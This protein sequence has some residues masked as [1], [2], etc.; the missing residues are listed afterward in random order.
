MNYAEPLGGKAGEVAAEVLSNSER[1][2]R[3]DLE[4]FA[5]LVERGELGG[6]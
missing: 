1:E 5:R 6:A 3:E 4:N 2:M